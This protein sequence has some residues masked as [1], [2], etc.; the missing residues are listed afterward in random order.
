[1][2]TMRLRMYRRTHIIFNYFLFLIFRFFSIAILSLRLLLLFSWC[3]LLYISFFQLRSNISSDLESS[4]ILKWFV[5]SFVRSFFPISLY[6]QDTT[7]QRS[8]TSE[9]QEATYTRE[10]Q[11]CVYRRDSYLM[12][13]SIGSSNEEKKG[14][15]KR[16]KN[17]HT[18]IH[19]PKIARRSQNPPATTHRI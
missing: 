6:A 3:S 13:N 11:M 7:A 1:M 17:T 15:L 5:R 12:S 18:H 19:I 4:H 9:E 14:N 8:I 2:Y 16:Q 10:W